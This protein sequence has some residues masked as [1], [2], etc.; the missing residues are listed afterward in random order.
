M[1]T[2]FHAELGHLQA[3]LERLAADAGA[4]V[5]E[6]CEALV[7]T[8]PARVAA[9]EHVETR[10]DFQE[11]RIE[12]EC[13]KIIALNQPVADELRYLA[14]VLRVNTALERLSDLS[15][16][17]VR[18][19]AEMV[20]EIVSDYRAKLAEVAGLIESML[21]DAVRSLAARDAVSAR[22]VWL[23]HD[24]LRGL[25]RSLTERLRQAIMGH[26]DGAQTRLALL[27]AVVNMERMGDHAA[28]I[29]KSVLYLVLGQVVRHRSREFLAKGRKTRVLFVCVHNSARSLMAEAW[30][31]HLH[32]ARYEAESA[33]L[34]PGMLNPLA[35]QAMRE[36]G[37]D[38]SGSRPRSVEEALA[39]ARPFDYVITVCDASSA[40]R[41]PPVLGIAEQIQWEFDDPAALTGTDAEKLAKIQIIRDAIR[42]KIDRWVAAVSV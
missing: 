7:M 13:L 23:R 1:R 20:P 28:D 17:M 3:M 16:D 34:T 15:E 41:C 27:V 33:G 19:V 5:H 40:E 6:A 42:I 10:I 14:A 4:N 18:D 24:T 36:V 9:V 32:G 21:G 26:E 29:S 35:V 12:E 22:D 38:L 11:V 39:V 8:A 2:H 30:L 31:N 25:C 37:I